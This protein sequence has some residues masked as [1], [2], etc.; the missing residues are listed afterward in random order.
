MKKALRIGYNRYYCDENFNEHIAYIKKNIALIDEVTLFAE[1]SHYGY[2]DEAFTEKSTTLLQKRIEQYRQAGV[3]SV[4]INLLDTRG[5]LEE[6][7][8]VLSKT[9][10]QHEVNP[11]GVVSQCILCHAN[12]DF[13]EYIAK[14]YSA[15]AKTGADFIWMDDDLRFGN[16]GLGCLCDECIRKFN[17]AYGY[18]C[19][20]IQLLEKIKTDSV[21]NQAWFAYQ[22][23]L[24]NRLVEVIQKAIKET[25]PNVKIGIM[26]IRPEPELSVVSGAVMGRPG[27][28]F[29]DDR[30]PLD[31]FTKAVKVQMQALSYPD[32]I[33]DIQYEYEAFNYQSLDKSMHISELETS[34]ALMSGC[35]GV[36]YNNDIFYDRQPFMDMLAKSA[37]KWDAL[38]ERNEKLRP[39]GVYCSNYGTYVKLNEVGIPVSDD[40]DFA[41]CCF[42]EGDTW[43][44]LDDETV[45]KIMDKGVMTDGRG[46][47]ILCEKGY[48]RLC[49]G[50]VKQSYASGMAERF[51]NHVLCGK[52]RNHYRDAFMNFSFYINNSGEAYALEPSEQA[53]IVSYLE[54]ITHD[55]IGC[56]LY[57]YAGDGGTRFAAD[58]Y[59]FRN[60]IKTHAKKEQIVNVLDWLSGAKLP[61]KTKETIKI[62]PT[63]R[64]DETGN[65]TVMLVNASFDKTGVFTCEIRNDKKFYIL[66]QSGEL[67]SVEQTVKNGNTTVTIDN[68]DGW[69]YVLLTNMK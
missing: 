62:V 54:T 8:G 9:D 61:V 3:K 52:Y 6:G 45:K 67:Q 56:S 47:A 18:D 43:N 26:S 31:I 24:L 34:L 19:D 5:H 29:Y 20:R 38:T 60:S 32:R 12:E 17:Q 36:L 41:V 14:R 42:I 13:E 64:M 23:T 15:Y 11:E 49:G 69:D 7:W 21:L 28:G 63:V 48:A 53:E 51:S 40:L 16:N 66:D 59:F 27:G 44:G 33:T 22:N 55:K 30:T 65:M 57:V 39:A 68:I 10:L 4:G 50:T 58:G 46:L 35:N 37:K 25:N 1:F 2:W